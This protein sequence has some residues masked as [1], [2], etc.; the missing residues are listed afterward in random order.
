MKT[1]FLYFVSI[2]FYSCIFYISANCVDLWLNYKTQISQNKPNFHHSQLT[3]TP[4]YLRT[5]NDELRT[6][7]A[8]NKPKQTQFKAIFENFLMQFY[9]SRS[10]FRLFGFSSFGFVSDFEIRISNLMN[11]AFCILIFDVFRGPQY[12]YRAVLQNKP[13][14]PEAAICSK[15]LSLKE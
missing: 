6:G 7:A 13:N 2:P 8:K 5:T 1:W 10:L 12:F 9:R 3:V 11:L 14:F 4:Y 15:S